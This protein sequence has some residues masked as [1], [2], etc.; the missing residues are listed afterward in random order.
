M[1]IVGYIGVIVHSLS[2]F[3]N[4]LSKTSPMI[5]IGFSITSCGVN[6]F[7]SCAGLFGMRVNKVDKE[8]NL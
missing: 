4:L 1:N 3:K 6:I 2:P 5:V 8:S 7:I